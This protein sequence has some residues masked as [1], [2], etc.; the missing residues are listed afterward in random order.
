M[1][2]CPRPDIL[3][4]PAMLFMSSGQGRAQEAPDGP[5]HP[6]PCTDTW[7]HLRPP[8]L[9]PLPAEMFIKTK[10]VFRHLVLAQWEDMIYFFNVGHT[11]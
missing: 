10:F 9:Y 8:Q 11:V 5:I 1:I 6:G 4:G 3:D 2:G 7:R